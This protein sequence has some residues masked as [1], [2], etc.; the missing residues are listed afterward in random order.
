MKVLII[1]GILAAVV[2][3]AAA[4]II[5]KLSKHLATM[6]RCGCRKKRS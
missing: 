6:S 1:C 5:Y 2:L 3:I 4:V